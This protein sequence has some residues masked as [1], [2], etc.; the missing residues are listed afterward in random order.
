[1]LRA[2]RALLLKARWPQRW[3]LARCRR[4]GFLL[5]R[6]VLVLYNIPMSYTTA[7]ARASQLA[8]LP[9][10]TMVV[11]ALLGIEASDE[12]KVDRRSESQCSASS[13]PLLRGCRARPPGA[14]RGELIMTAAVLCM[15]FLTTSGPVRSFSD[16]ARSASPPSDGHGAAALILVGSLTGGV[17]S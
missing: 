16:R 17:R 4:I 2:A 6:R 10:H 8:T 12:R 14:W 11:G 15:A 7:A 3:G 9:L 13:P 1:L 5:L